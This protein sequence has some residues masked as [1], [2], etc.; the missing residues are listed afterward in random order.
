MANQYIKCV[1]RRYMQIFSFKK[2]C[3]P[4]KAHV[5]RRMFC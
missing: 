4:R 5:S 3:G 1:L 2:E